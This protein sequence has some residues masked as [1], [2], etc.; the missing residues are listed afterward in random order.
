MWKKRLFK[1][2]RGKEHRFSSPVNGTKRLMVA[3]GEGGI[4]LNGA[5]SDRSAS[6]SPS[7]LAAHIKEEMEMDNML[8]RNVVYPVIGEAGQGTML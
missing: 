1:Q 7:L 6:S 8:Q 5:C 3:E 4:P 2:R